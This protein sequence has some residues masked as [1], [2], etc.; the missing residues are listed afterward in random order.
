MRLARGTVEQLPQLLPTVTSVS[1]DSDLDIEEASDAVFLI[2]SE[3]RI[4][5]VNVLA[6]EL[7]GESRDD[8]VGEMF[9]DW[10]HCESDPR[11]RLA[12]PPRGLRFV[13]ARRG[14]FMYQRNGERLGLDL[15]V[16]SDEQGNGIIL[17][18][19][20]AARH[21]DSLREEEV[22]EI[23]HDLKSPL[24]TIALDAQLLSQRRSDE[25][26]HA[27]QCARIERNIVYMDRLVQELLDLC[28][29]DAGKLQLDR[30]PAE[31]G[32]VLQH[33]L[34]RVP[35]G[36]R[37]RIRVEVQG[38][39]VVACDEPR[40]ERVLANFVENALKYGHRGSDVIVRLTI[41][42]S[43]AR[44]SVIDD[45]PG[46]TAQ[47]AAGVFDK[48]KRASSSIGQ[49]GSGLGLFV[50]RK[51]IE[52]HGGRIGVE[53]MKGAGSRF[54]FELPVSARAGAKVEVA[55]RVARVRRYILIVDDER[56]Q[57]EGLAELLHDEGYET[58]VA[59]TAGQG[60]QL[61]RTRRP[62]VVVADARLRGTSGV[63]MLFR[64]EQELGTF[65]SIVLT[66]LPPEDPNVASAVRRLG[67]VYV[68]KPVD[69]DRLVSVLQWT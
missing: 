60:I 43:C 27:S 13:S 7:L 23:V 9:D 10:I 64:L 29:I 8:L 21:R 62:D 58:A 46:L 33:V 32:D 26:M 59:L 47:E 54:Y 34:A 1:F 14:V 65:S 51:I 67:S 50:C 40:I 63:D 4:T 55:R 45:G 37:S 30:K 36:E 20:S 15:T 66:G 18:R 49:P 5:S 6:E 44:V 28:A 3:G 53:S 2:N 57:A 16:C 56:D 12:I 61:A 31:L 52:A 17:A 22:A 41:A 38:P 48:F 39:V 69:I 42:A 35:S 25:D 68:P 19:P 11:S 24:A